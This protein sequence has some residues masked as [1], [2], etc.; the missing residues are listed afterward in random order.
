ME[1]GKMQKAMFNGAKS[2]A[3]NSL[4]TTIDIFQDQ[5]KKARDTLIKQTEN[6]EKYMMDLM[7]YSRMALDDGLKMMEEL[8]YNNNSFYAPWIDAWSKLPE[9]Q[10][11]AYQMWAAALTQL[12]VPIWEETLSSEN[13]KYSKKK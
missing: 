2:T 13:E 4:D 3:L 10:K 9:I 12:A 6:T 8:V 5:T 1:L 11:N 7:K